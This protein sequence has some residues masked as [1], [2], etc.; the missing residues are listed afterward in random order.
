MVD[1]TCGYDVMNESTKSHR[2]GMG[3]VIRAANELFPCV[4]RCLGSA[5]HIGE[6]R[7]PQHRMMFSNVLQPGHRTL[8]GVSRP[9]NV[10]FTWLSAR[11]GKHVASDDGSVF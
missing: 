6:R 9:F 7:K 4:L 10:L 11:E 2:E 5:D 8:D 3:Y 1:L